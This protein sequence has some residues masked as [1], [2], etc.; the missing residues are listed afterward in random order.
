MCCNACCRVL[1]GVAVCC[2]MLQYVA[3]F[4]SMLQCVAVVQCVVLCCSVLQCV[5]QCVAVCCSLLQCVAAC[6]SVLQCVAVCC[7]ACCSVLYTLT[8]TLIYTQKKYDM[9]SKVSYPQ[10][11]PSIQP[12]HTLN[13]APIVHAK[14]PHSPSKATYLHL[15]ETYH[16]VKRASNTHKIYARNRT[17]LSF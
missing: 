11:Y 5:L 12:Y 3:P 2:R 16:T 4:G 17:L 7:S 8:R 1:Q 13:R 10:S 9:H 6:C 14:Q 15:K